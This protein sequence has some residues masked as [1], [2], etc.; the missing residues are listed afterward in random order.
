M[1]QV[2]RHVGAL[3]RSSVLGNEVLRAGS[4]GRQLHAVHRLAILAQ[5][6]W[7][8]LQVHQEAAARSDAAAIRDVVVY[9][10]SLQGGAEVGRHIRMQ[11]LQ[12][13][14]VSAARGASLFH[15][16]FSSG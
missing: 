10:K 11:L 5:A 6:Q 2:G 8:L 14:Q 1:V 15:K 13:D 4:P 9:C 16:L 3:Q 12:D 7:Q